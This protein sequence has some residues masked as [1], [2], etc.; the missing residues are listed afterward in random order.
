[1]KKFKNI[2]IAEEMIK[3]RETSEIFHWPLNHFLTAQFQEFGFQ[4]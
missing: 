1:M 4:V 3:P 2:L